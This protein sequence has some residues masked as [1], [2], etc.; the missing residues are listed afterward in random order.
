MPNQAIHHSKS[1]LYNV[2]TF[3]GMAFLR[4]IQTSNATEL[5]R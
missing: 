2:L 4:R 3:L 1:T 5:M